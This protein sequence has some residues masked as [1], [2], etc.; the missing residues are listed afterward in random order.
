MGY[1]FQM[2][3]PTHLHQN[4]A[5]AEETQDLETSDESDRQD[6]E[7]QPPIAGLS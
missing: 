1:F 7:A 3:S 2:M 6:L 5:A 4:P